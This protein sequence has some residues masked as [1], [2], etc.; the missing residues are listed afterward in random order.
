M[1]TVGKLAIVAGVASSQLVADDVAAMASG[2]AIA[3]KLPAWV[4]GALGGPNLVGRSL[5]GGSCSEARLFD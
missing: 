4:T 3:G 1:G 2:S 5:S